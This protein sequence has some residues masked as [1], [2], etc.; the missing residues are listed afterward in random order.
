MKNPRI[1]QIVGFSDS[2]KTT[3]ISSLI[4]VLKKKKLK[5]LTIKSA[6][7]HKYSLSKKDTDIFIESGSD[8]SVAVFENVTQIT[9][10]SQL[11]VS[12]IIEY[13]TNLIKPD[14]ILIEG[15]KEKKYPKVLFWTKEFADSLKIIETRDI[16]YVYSSDKNYKEF[17]RRITEFVDKTNAFLE[18]DI[19]KLIKRIV[20]DFKL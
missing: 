13:S 5:V 10:N 2:G 20:E 19:Y 3:F 9:Y 12:E 8:L 7:N 18:N 17:E 16:L 4:K 14:I 6:R 15:F 11:D 1:L